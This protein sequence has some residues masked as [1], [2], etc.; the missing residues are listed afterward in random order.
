MRASTQAAAADQKIQGIQLPSARSHRVQ[1]DVRILDGFEPR[2]DAP[3]FART[4]YRPREGR[5]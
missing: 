1:E 5:A 2:I 3:Y 4:V